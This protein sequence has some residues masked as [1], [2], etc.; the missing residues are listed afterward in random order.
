MLYR[1]VQEE[2]TV[3]WLADDAQ[4]QPHIASSHLR[5]MQRQRIARGVRR[6]KFVFYRVIDQR[7]VDIVG[8]I[9]DAPHSP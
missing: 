8:S 5:A 1:M 6:G 3:S 7:V 9:T 4:V 2:R